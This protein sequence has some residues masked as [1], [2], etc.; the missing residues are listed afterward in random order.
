VSFKICSTYQL[1]LRA[2]S[3]LNLNAGPLGPGE[4]TIAE[5]VISADPLSSDPQDSY[6]ND[7]QNSSFFSAHD[8]NL[9][10]FKVIYRAFF[11]QKFNASFNS[12]L[13]SQ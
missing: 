7:G 6:G 4:S 2:D 10:E 13:S 9:N 3:D 1:K 8:I 5:Q 12:L 11:L